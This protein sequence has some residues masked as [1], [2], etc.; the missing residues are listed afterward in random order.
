MSGGLAVLL[1]TVFLVRVE[2]ERRA[3]RLPIR[4]SAAEPEEVVPVRRVWREPELP[5]RKVATQPPR[6]DFGP[7]MLQAWLLG[8]SDAEFSALM[9]DG[10][11]YRYVDRVTD[12]L[13]GRPD[14]V[15]A[16]ALFMTQINMRIHALRKTR[17]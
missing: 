11:L 9:E 12:Y 3:R 1:A 16:V 10:S 13:D 6:A 15:E 4:T 14:A 7:E 2:P 5:P 17:D 8:L